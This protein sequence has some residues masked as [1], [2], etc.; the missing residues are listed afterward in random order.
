MDSIAQIDAISLFL[1]DK[2]GLR[3]HTVLDRDFVT[4]DDYITFVCAGRTQTQA[5]SEA[6]TDDAGRAVFELELTARQMKDEVTFYMTAGGTQ[7]ASRQYSVR[8]YADQLLADNSVTAEEKNLVRA[9][10][11]YGSYTQIYVGYNIENLASEGI[12]TDGTDPV[13][14]LENP[15]LSSYNYSYT[16]NDREDGL[17]IDSI[18]LLLGTDISIRFYYTPG[19]EGRAYTFSLEGGF[20]KPV[21]TGYDEQKG[22]FYASVDHLTPRELSTMYTCNFYSENASEEEPAAS[23]TLG[24]LSYCKG[25]LEDENSSEE[26]KNLCKAIYYYKEAVGNYLQ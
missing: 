20:E 26:I 19:Q 23:V 11:N 7:G 24:A 18:S 14:W 10:L 8:Q 6:D 3:V 2:I 1:T 22:A 12:Y 21:S 16:I 17:T 15:D 5:V 25:I 9:M 4:D 13:Q